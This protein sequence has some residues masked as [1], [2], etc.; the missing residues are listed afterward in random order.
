MERLSLHAF[1]DE[2]K[3]IAVAGQV[4]KP[5]TPPKTSAPT[6]APSA[7]LAPAPSAKPPKLGVPVAQNPVPNQIR[8]P[9]LRAQVANMQR[10]QDVKTPAPPRRPGTLKPAPAHAPNIRRVATLP[11]RPATP[12]VQQATNQQHFMQRYMVPQTRQSLGISAPFNPGI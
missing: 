3:K 8:N 1:V 5:P 10:Y 11:T 4:T 9:G 6:P 7:K 12:P 2:L